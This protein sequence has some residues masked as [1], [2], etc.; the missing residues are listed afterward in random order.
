MKKAKI[1]LSFDDARKDNYTVVYPM[2]KK[3]GLCATLNVTTGFVMREPE[4]MNAAKGYEPMTKENVIELYQSGVFEIGAHGHFHKNTQEDIKKGVEILTEWLGENWRN[5]GIGFASPYDSIGEDR[6]N[7]E[8]DFFENT[9]II[10]V[11]G[12]RYLR[13]FWHRLQNKILEVVVKDKEK[14]AYW[15]AKLC[16]QSPKK[17]SFF[18]SVSTNIDT[19]V[20]LWKSIIDKAAHDG[21]TCIFMIHSVLTPEDAMYGARYSY[22]AG[23]FETICQYLRKLV[24]EGKIE[25]KT[26]MEIFKDGE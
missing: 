15:C 20:E 23:K 2:L 24:D 9:N 17:R 4:A 26:N 13:D 1:C 8:R 25:V 3:Y 22:E 10:Y 16:M 19:S 18:R 11:R 14:F 12:N 21:K 6:F 7:A 5:N